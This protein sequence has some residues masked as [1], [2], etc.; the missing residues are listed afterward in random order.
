MQLTYIIRLPDNATPS[1]IL[2]AIAQ[3]GRSEQGWKRTETKKVANLENKCGSCEHFRPYVY[4]ENEGGCAKGHA[5]G[6]RSRPRCKE[7]ERRKQCPGE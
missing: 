7:Y 1:E 3:A 4:G 5:W 2:N 6:K